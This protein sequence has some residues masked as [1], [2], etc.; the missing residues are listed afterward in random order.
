MALLSLSPTI[1][2]LSLFPLL[3]VFSLFYDDR[4]L[5]YKYST[6]Y[7][8]PTYL[9]LQYLYPC[10]WY[11]WGTGRYCT[12]LIPSYPHIR[13]L[14]WWLVVAKKRLTGRFGLIHSF[15]HTFVHAF[16]VSSSCRRFYKLI[17]KYKYALSKTVS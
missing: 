7:K 5:P 9:P 2:N 15:I 1:F 10:T 8:V 17:A 6:G 13:D 16:V 14:C 12:Y 11:L 3:Y 4:H